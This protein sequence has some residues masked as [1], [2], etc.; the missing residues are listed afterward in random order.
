MRFAVAFN[1]DLLADVEDFNRYNL[2]CL[3]LLR[4]S[5][6]NAWVPLFISFPEG[7]PLGD[8]GVKIMSSH[9]SSVENYTSSSDKVKKQN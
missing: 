3:K 7:C 2:V 9:S 6:M 8:F 4:L 5:T 1:L